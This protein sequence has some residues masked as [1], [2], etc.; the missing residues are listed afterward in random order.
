L[1]KEKYG[2]NIL[3][4]LIF[5]LEPILQKN[6]VETKKSETMCETFYKKMTEK[7]ENNF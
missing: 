5:Y 4:L 1:E 7:C 3:N 6:G 2:R